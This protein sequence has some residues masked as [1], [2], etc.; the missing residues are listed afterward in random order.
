MARPSKPLIIPEAYQRGDRWDDWITEFENVATVNDWDA[1][2]KLNWIKVCLAGRAQKAFQ[3]LPEGAR[4]TY[5]H[6][7]TA[8]I[9]RF[10]RESK[11]ELYIAELQV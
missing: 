10:K 4:D 8:L 5:N 3:G 1:A 2:A 7:K 6:V 9:E 11:C